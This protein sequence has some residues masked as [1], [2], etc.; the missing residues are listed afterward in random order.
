MV[1]LLYIYIII[2]IYNYDPN[3]DN[4]DVEFDTIGIKSS[5]PPRRTIVVEIS[6]Q[7]AFVNKLASVS[8]TKK[9]LQEKV[10]VGKKKKLSSAVTGNIAS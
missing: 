7:F 3:L 1:I 6:S 8:S 2:I 10:Y 5:I 4:V 9:S